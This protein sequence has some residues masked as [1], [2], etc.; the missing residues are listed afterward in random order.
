MPEVSA[1]RRPALDPIALARRLLAGAG[2]ED[3]RLDAEV[4]MAEAA[5]VARADVLA[6]LSALSPETLA[7]FEAMIARRMTR[8]PVAHIVG[9]KEFYSLD[10][11]VSPAVLIPRPETETIVAAALKSIANLAEARVLDIGTGSGAIAIS[12]AAN[13]RHAQVLATDISADALAIAKRNAVRHQVQDRV[14][15]RLADCFAML[16][17][18]APLARFDLIV[19]NPPYVDDAEIA[20]LAPE[21]RSFEPHVALSAGRDGLDFYRRIAAG[22][23]SHL[24]R[25]GGLMVEVG[26]GQ[27]RAVSEIFAAHAL[28]VVSVIDD[29][30][31][32]QRVVH[33]RMTPV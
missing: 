27:A 28:R 6:G 12:I 29:L 23:R 25:E 33:A 20:R 26:A 5:G 9:H 14:T 31:G 10:F 13:A 32:H 11:E 21:V 24:V 15:Q 2:V 4:L 16:D 18:G 30:A 22:A 3:A 17:D 8:E 7:R 1:Q 19:S